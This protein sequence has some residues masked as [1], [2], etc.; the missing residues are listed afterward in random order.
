M[1]YRIMQGNVSPDGLEKVV[2]YIQS[3]EGFLAEVQGFRSG[4][5]VVDSAGNG[6]M[7]AEYTSEDAYRADEAGINEKLAE[8]APLLAGPPS[9]LAAGTSAWSLVK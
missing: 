1:Y 4:R 6:V 3:V 5:Y 8:L 7:I 2:A 9:L